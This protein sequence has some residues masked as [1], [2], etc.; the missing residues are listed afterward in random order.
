MTIPDEGAFFRVC[1]VHYI[2]PPARDVA[3]VAREAY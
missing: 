3:A 1:Q 2:E